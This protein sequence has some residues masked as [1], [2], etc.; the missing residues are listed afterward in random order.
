[1]H[2]ARKA[3]PAP[4]LIAGPTASGKSALAI[5]LAERFGGCVINADALQVYD[6]WRILTARPG[7]E[8]T[9]RVPHRLY[10][11]VSPAQAHSVGRWLREIGPVLDACAAE[12][13]R[14]VIVGGTGLY[15]R[16]LT[17]GLAVIPDPGAEARA[18]AERLCALGGTRA[19][20][21]WLEAHDPRTL[22]GIDAMNPMRLMRAVAVRSGTG[23]GLSAWQAETPPP[24][25]PLAG[26][27]A[28]KLNPPRQVLEARIA[29][30]LAA[31]PEEGVLAEAAA[32]AAMGLPQSAPAMKAV[33]A[34][35]F[36]ACLAGA[37]DLDTAIT[38][39]SLA[40]RRY[41]K[42]QRTWLRNRMVS[43]TGLESQENCEILEIATHH[44][45]SAG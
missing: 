43:W 19:L 15:F 40:T 35:E 17:E 27:I 38:R 25:L 41:A 29:A 11:H 32:I 42:R 7:P 4:I 30:R 16:A 2:A 22:A 12:G 37:I 5:G 8:E 31:M 13:L 24:V 3:M 39:A 45:I 14:P 10:G 6:G 18:M 36:M 9:A 26:C 20:A 23:R 34:A 44:V 33:G 21:A 1:M 28:L